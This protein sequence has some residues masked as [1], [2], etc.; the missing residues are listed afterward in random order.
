ME[1]CYRLEKKTWIYMDTEKAVLHFCKKYCQ[2][3]LFLIDKK[4][5]FKFSLKEIS[6]SGTK[7]IWSFQLVCKS[8][9][10][11]NVTLKYHAS[12]S[13]SIMSNSLPPYGLESPWNSLGQNMG[14]GSF[15]FSSRF[16]QPRN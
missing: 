11:C 15:P 6:N 3:C 10:N 8:P 13:R 9:R 12:E 1:F 5:N 16:S 7:S 4:M 2:Q 14:V